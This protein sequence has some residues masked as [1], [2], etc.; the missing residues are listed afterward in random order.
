VPR[1][2]GLRLAAWIG[3][4]GVPVAA[5]LCAVLGVSVPSIVGLVMIVW[6]V[7]GFGYLVA[8]MS[9]RDPDSG[10]DDGAVL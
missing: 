1:P 9:G 10:W 7:A 4:F 6:F 3:L 8:T 2:R 5:L